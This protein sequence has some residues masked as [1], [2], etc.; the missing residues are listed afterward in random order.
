MGVG[1]VGVYVG[2]CVFVCLCMC[3]EMRKRK[4]R[5]REKRERI[6][7]VVDSSDALIAVLCGYSCCASE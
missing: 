1:V 6:T 2:G 4:R 7:V 3:V 5:E